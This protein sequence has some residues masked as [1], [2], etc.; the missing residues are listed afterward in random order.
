VRCW[1]EGRCLPPL[2]EKVARQP[3]PA[4][5]AAHP[6]AAR[7]TTGSPPSKTGSGSPADQWDGTPPAWIHMLPPISPPRMSSPG[8]AIT[9]Q[10]DESSGA[11]SPS[12][13]AVCRTAASR[14][15]SAGD[16]LSRHSPHRRGAA[17]FAGIC[18]GME[19]IA[20]EWAV[21][22]AQPT[23]LSRTKGLTTFVQTKGRAS[24]TCSSERQPSHEG[25][26]DPTNPEPAS[27][28]TRGEIDV[29]ST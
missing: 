26:P 12:T 2:N 20:T 5:A 6:D 3:C 25:C 4:T 13:P 28:P 11:S 15:Q 18:A 17:A 16:R 19:C 24:K 1:E 9:V 10:S 7:K 27:E 14:I 21:S 22:A 29:R 23:G 8:I